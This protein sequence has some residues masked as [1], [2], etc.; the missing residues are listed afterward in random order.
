MRVCKKKASDAT[1]GNAPTQRS[2]SQRPSVQYLNKQEEQDDEFQIF[3][4]GQTAPEPSIIIPLEINGVPVPMELDTGAS[5]TVISET[6]WKEKFPTSTLEPSNI[7]LKT[8]TGEELKVL[9]QATV[10]IKYGE[11]NCNLP[12]QIV[13][14]NGPA[15]FG[16]NWLKDIKLN[17][18]TIKKV[19][20][21]LDDVLTRHK[22]V[23]K[24]ELGTMKD[25]KAK[26][27]IKPGATPKFFKP[28]SVPNALKGAIEMELDR[29]EGMG[30]IEKVRYSEW[31]APIVPVVKADK[32]IRV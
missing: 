15:L 20:Y 2:S 5:L 19:T 7:R 26:L 16:R 17:W 32:S 25:V 13:K 1:K 18:G 9:G 22:E 30:V 8:Y 4:I 31:A 12:V 23:F 10:A 24:D 14:G 29:L 28:R 27:Y 3:K 11:Q 21:D 6:L